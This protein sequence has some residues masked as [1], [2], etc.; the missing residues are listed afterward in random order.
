MTLENLQPRERRALALGILLLVLV[1]VGVGVVKP[2][3]DRYRLY[4]DAVADLGF[5]LERLAQVAA[6]GPALDER[7][8]D[9][10]ETVRSAGLAVERE[11]PALAAADLQR[12]L[13][14]VVADKGGNVRSTLVMAPQEEEGFVRVAVRMQMSGDSEVLAEVLEA[15]ESARP[16]IFVDN[17]RIQGRRGV[18]RRGTPDPG[19]EQVEAQ[20]DAMVFMRGG[21]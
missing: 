6:Q 4:H 21:E 19:A 10:T 7:V 14:E 1:A 15:V 8:A 2:V 18:V 5:R 9:L 13:G 16:L 3:V 12:R 11:T 20:F 17:V